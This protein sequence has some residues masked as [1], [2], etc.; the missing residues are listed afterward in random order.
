MDNEDSMIVSDMHS[1]IYKGVSFVYPKA[2]H[3]ACV[4]HLERNI[5][6]KFKKPGLSVLFLGATKTF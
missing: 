4:I 6:S 5:T 1:Y 3:G 2:T